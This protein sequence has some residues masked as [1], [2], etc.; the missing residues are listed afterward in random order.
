MLYGLGLFALVAGASK[1][2]A[3]AVWGAYTPQWFLAAV[4]VSATAWM[5]VVGAIEASVGVLILSRW[6]SHVWTGVAAV[7]LL[8]VTLAVA[9]GGFYDVAW[10]DFGLALFAAVVSLNEYGR[11]HQD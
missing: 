5:Y 4:P 2:V 3:P 7:W 8:V 10:R 11:R 9:S 6:K 1:F